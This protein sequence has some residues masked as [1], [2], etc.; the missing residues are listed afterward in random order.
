MS[1]LPSQLDCDLAEAGVLVTRARHQAG[2]LC[3]MIAERGGRPLRFPVV[4]ICDPLDPAAVQTILLEIDQY[5]M[6][7][8]VSPNAVL[9]GLKLMPD[10]LLPPAL[11]LGAIGK[12][13]AR[14]L[15]EA[16]YP[17]DIVPEHQFDSEALL[18]TQE[19]KQVAGKRI[20]IVRGSGGRELLA[21]ELQARGAEVVYVEVYRRSCPKVDAQRLIYRWTDDVDVVTVT[22]IH[23][24]ENL[25]A[26]LGSEGKNLLNQTPIVVI[27][28]RMRQRARELG[29][30]QVILARGADEEQLMEALCVWIKN[31]G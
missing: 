29:C 10:G 16:G 22:S 31:R 18:E 21:D 1:I 8:F 28:D 6:A 17:V 5:D 4:D 12:Q 24:L 26:L 25:N 14:T 19:L 13:T 27:S 20:L 30:Q 3:R 15:A 23:L 9:W 11:E 7:I 2:A